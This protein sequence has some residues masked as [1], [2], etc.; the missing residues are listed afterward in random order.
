MISKIQGFEKKKYFFNILAFLDKSIFFFVNFV[1]ISNSLIIMRPIINIL[2]ILWTIVNILAILRRV[3]S[4][5][6]EYFGRSQE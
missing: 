2:V 6:F 1:A 3:P 5:I 4:N